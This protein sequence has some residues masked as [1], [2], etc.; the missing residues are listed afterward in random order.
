L[1]AILWV[2]GEGDNPRE[3][4]AVGEEEGE[5][6]GEKEGEEMGLSNSSGW[7]IFLRL[8]N[9]TGALRL[10]CGGTWV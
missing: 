5:E 6:K 9:P 1:A 3:G 10:W 2:V 8:G 4:E 7:D